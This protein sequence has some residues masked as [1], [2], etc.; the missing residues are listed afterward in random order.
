MPA[1]ASAGPPASLTGIVA[2]PTDPSVIILRYENVLGGLFYSQDGAH[3][4]RA[5]LATIFTRVG[6]RAGSR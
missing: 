2:H 6:L 3:T 5:C 1:G 4:F